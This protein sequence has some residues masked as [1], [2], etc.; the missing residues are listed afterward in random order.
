MMNNSDPYKDLMK[1]Q[2]IMMNNSGP[3]KA[4][5][6]DNKYTDNV[7]PVIYF[8]RIKNNASHIMS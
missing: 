4:H 6:A 3:Y 2:M 1:S 8:M 5:V 7:V